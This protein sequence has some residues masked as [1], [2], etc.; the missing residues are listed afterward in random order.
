MQ[1]R[2]ELRRGVRIP[3]EVILPGWDEPVRL[4]ASDL[5]PVGAYIESDLLPDRGEHLVCCFGLSRRDE[6]CLFADVTRVN[7]LRRRH[8]L[9]RAGFAVSFLDARPLE[10]LRMRQM[11][12]GLPPPVPRPSRD[13]DP[14][15]LEWVG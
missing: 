11:L 13:D 4:L 9:G 1:K 6:Y 15:F 14:L 3:F 5:S 2:W 8:D 7:P 12:R 10:R